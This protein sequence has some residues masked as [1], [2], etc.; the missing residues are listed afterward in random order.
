MVP[1]SVGIPLVAFLALG[2]D[3]AGARPDITWREARVVLSVG[4]TNARDSLSFGALSGLAVTSDRRI[5]VADAQLSQIILVSAEAKFVGRVGRRGE[6]PGEFQVP[7]G[8]HIDSDD[9]LWVRDRVLG[10]VSVFGQQGEPRQTVAL[11]F[12]PRMVP[13]RPLVWHGELFDWEVGLDSLA[14]GVTTYTLKPV[15]DA[16]R[17]PLAR[18]RFEED[19]IP[20]SRLRRPYARD[21]EVAVSDD[22]WLWEAHTDEAVVRGRSLFG[23][24]T[25]ELRFP[26]EAIPVPRDE[27]RRIAA[28]WSETMDVSPSD[29]APTYPPILRLVT[30]EDGGVAVL[31]RDLDSAS[32][33]TLFVFEGGRT[34]AYYLPRTIQVTPPPTVRHGSLYAVA[35]DDMSAAEVLVIDLS[36]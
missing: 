17:P 30:T 8:I 2:C 11:P 25:R 31:A 6:G 13:W 4:G 18:I 35:L 10:R 23:A 32:G 33:Q 9:G 12:R 21:L 28:G 20:G 14:S 24:G 5:A 26:L 15:E 27:A 16:S 1:R 36:W 7:D 34:R 29:V 19:L 3:G 22:G